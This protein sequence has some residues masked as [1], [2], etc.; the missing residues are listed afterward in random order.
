[1]Q[2]SCMPMANGE[3]GGP[4]RRNSVKDVGQSERRRAGACACHDCGRR[5]GVHL[6]RCNET[7][8]T[9]QAPTTRRVLILSV[10][11][12]AQV[13]CP[14]DADRGFSQCPTQDAGPMPRSS[15]GRLRPWT[16]CRLAHVQ[17]GAVRLV[18]PA[19]HAI[20]QCF[21]PEHGRD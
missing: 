17:R 6:K 3:S 2:I 7:T 4:W 15:R 20:R 13:Y 5:T 21:A 18:A 19:G 10:Y 11:L 14:G 9:R 8:P 1:M 12:G 16:L